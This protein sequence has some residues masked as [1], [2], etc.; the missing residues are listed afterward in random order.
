VR[1][2]GQSWGVFEALEFPS[3]A[4][5]LL[6]STSGCEN[7]VPQ[8]TGQMDETKWRAY[9]TLVVVVFMRFS[10]SP[11]SPEIVERS[12]GKSF[13]FFKTADIAGLTS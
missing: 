11:P 6:F 12:S 2:I 7:L 3:Q 5:L 4:D 9:W 8:P 1:Q 13:E 10:L